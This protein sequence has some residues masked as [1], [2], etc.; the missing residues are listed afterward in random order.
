MSSEF[1]GRTFDQS[2]LA[3]VPMIDLIAR[4]GTTIGYVSQS[5]SATIADDVSAERLRVQPGSPLLKLRRVF[6]DNGDRPVYF[7]DLF[8]ARPLRY[9]MTL[10]RGADNQFRLDGQRT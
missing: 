5:I 1:I 2:E 6:Y 3:V 4:S 9:R 10:S 8:I 7:A